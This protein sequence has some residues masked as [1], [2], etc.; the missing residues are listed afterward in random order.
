MLH[1]LYKIGSFIH[2][3]SSPIFAFLLPKETD[4]CIYCSIDFFL[5][6]QN[7]ASAVITLYTHPTKTR[8][9]FISNLKQLVSGLLPWDFIWLV[10]VLNL[11]IFQSPN[12][13][14]NTI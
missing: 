1:I 5:Q 11:T 3:Y 13:T 4:D 8:Y 10:T 14:A 9:P 7:S 2:L 6:W 12:D